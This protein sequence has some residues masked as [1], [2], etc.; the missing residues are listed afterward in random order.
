MMQVLYPEI[1]PYAEH[2]LDVG[3]GHQIYIEESGSPKGLPVLYV[4]G[5]PGTG[6]ISY[7]RRFFD[8]EKFRIIL[9]D[10]RGCGR[11][12]ADN[13]LEANTTE[14]LL[15][16][17]EAI[18]EHLEVD[19]WVIFGGGWGGTLALLYAQSFNMRVHGLIIHSVFLGREADVDW[20]FRTGIPRLV[21]D[22]WEEFVQSLHSKDH[23]NVL[24]VF[25]DRLG[26]T[27]ELAR[28]SAAKSWA[29]WYAKSS[30]LHHSNVWIKRFHDPHVAMTTAKIQAHYFRQ[31]CFLEDNRVIENAHKLSG[32]PGIIV[33]GRFDLLCPLDSAWLLQHHWPEAE[34]HVIR[35][36]CHANLDPGITD[37]LVR[38]SKDMHWIVTHDWT[39]S[40]SD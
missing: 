21:P 9:F 33:H 11:S 19:R 32:I 22:Y 1:K 17:L 36:A 18:R 10:Q 29:T 39:D 30:L 14:H 34:L 3:N 5:G 35:D 20:I 37:A 13:E 38:A 12:L 2:L 24:E 28:M 6:S 15:H 23:D 7:H 4:H 8:P 25:S 31:N 16:D 26:G 27:D 40:A